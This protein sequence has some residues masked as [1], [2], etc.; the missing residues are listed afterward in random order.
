[1][2]TGSEVQKN[3]LF[4][5]GNRREAFGSEKENQSFKRKLVL[6]I[7]PSL[8]PSVKGRMVKIR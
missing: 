2:E 4:G 7:G 6:E 5:V 8:L 1:M 3:G